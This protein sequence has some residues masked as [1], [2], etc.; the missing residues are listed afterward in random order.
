MLMH[1]LG[2]SE[3]C[4]QES[5]LVLL[6]R[7][8]TRKGRYTKF[9]RAKRMTLKLLKKTMPTIADHQRD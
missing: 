5:F 3:P 7:K 9:L 2:I 1:Y 4:K 8:T 6:K